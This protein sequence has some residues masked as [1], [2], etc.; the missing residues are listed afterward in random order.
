M[1]Y[2]PFDHI[3]DVKK[4]QKMADLA[5]KIKPYKGKYYIVVHPSMASDIK[6]LKWSS[7]LDD[8]VWEEP[9]FTIKRLY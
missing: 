4:I 6:E 2:Q 8:D 7:Y 1:N 5:K 3:L 9:V